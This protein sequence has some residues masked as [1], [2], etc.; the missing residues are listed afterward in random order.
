MAVLR[1]EIAWNGVMTDADDTSCA[2]P[3]FTNFVS[4]LNGRLVAASKP[5]LSHILAFYRHEPVL[6]LFL[7][8]ILMVFP[9]GNWVG[10]CRYIF[11]CSMTVLSFI[12]PYDWPWH[13]QLPKLSVAIGL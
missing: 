11:I 5:V 1:L 13:T 12:C 10:T 2:S 3:I 4:L 6:I 8:T 7:G 9:L